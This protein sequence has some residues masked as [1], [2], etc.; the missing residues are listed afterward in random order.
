VFPTAGAEASDSPLP[1]ALSHIVGDSHLLYH[2]LIFIGLFG[3]VASFHGII[4]ASGRAIYEM[5]NEHFLP[6]ILGKI[7]SRFH[8]SSNSLIL[9]MVIGFIALFTGHTGE[10]ITL[11]VFGALTLYIVSMISFF[12]LRKNFP[13]MKRPFKVPFY[14]YTPAI[15]LLL[16]IIALGAVIYYNFTLAL[17][18]ALIMGGSF[19]WFKLVAVR[20]P[21]FVP[22]KELKEEYVVRST[23]TK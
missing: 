7:N 10:I 12:K 23:E 20:R 4:L 6:S 3:L 8:T 18:Y 5:G 16:A 22:G 14:P 15:A 1:L 13:Q 11:A 19:V 2:M 17:I 21:A 9:S